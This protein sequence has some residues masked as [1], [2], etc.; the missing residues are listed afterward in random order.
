LLN[1]D[2]YGNWIGDDVQ[3]GRHL[4]ERSKLLLGCISFDFEVDADLLESSTNIFFES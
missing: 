4:T 1:V 2:L 3:N